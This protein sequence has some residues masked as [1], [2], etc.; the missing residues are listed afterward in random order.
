VVILMAEAHLCRDCNNLTVVRETEPNPCYWCGKAYKHVY[1]L[2]KR[3]F[4]AD[5]EPRNIRDAIPHPFCSV[6]GENAYFV[7]IYDDMDISYSPRC[8][9]HKSGTLN[10]DWLYIKQLNPEVLQGIIEQ[11]LASYPYDTPRFYVSRN[12]R[13][14][15]EYRQYLDSILKGLSKKQRETYLFIKGTGKGAILV[16]SLNEIQKD[17]LGKLRD[18]KLVEIYEIDKKYVHPNRGGKINIK[19]FKAVRTK[20]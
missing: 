13:R 6:C 1:S 7:Q 2:D 17:A 10:D 4:C 8:F 12:K 19:S 16:R 3:V 5:F 18:K 14:E 15:E 11:Q 9:D 20:K